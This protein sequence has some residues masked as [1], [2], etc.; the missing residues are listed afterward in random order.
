MTPL[1]ELLL[2]ACCI[3][4][5]GLFSGSE[6]AI[7]G[8][9]RLVL[10]A[11]A[12][13]GDSAAKRVLK[14]LERPTQLV[15]TCL[16]GTNV[17]TIAGATLVAHALGRFG[18]VPELL[19]VAVYTPLTI[20]FSEMVPKTI[21]Q[22]HAN[23][24]APLV[25]QPISALSVLLRPVLWAI[26]HATRIIMTVLGV[27]DAQVHAVRRED[28]QL[29]LDSATMTD[30]HD[31][32]KEMILRVFNFSETQVA[33]AMVP[34]I[35]V[36]GVPETATCGE[37]RSVMIDQGF[38]RLVIYRKRID[39]IVGMVMHSD[40]LFAPDDARPV[41]TVMHEIMFVPE[42]KRVDELFVD[43]RRKRQR[44]AVAVDEYGGAV[45]LISIEDILEEI[46]GDIEDEYDRA[47][48]LVRKM[49]ERQWI[50]SGRVE[51]EDLYE[52]T[53]FEMPEGDYETLAGFLLSQLGH[54][55]AAGERLAWGDFVLTVALA[56]ERA[57]LEV[58][59]QNTVP[60]T[61][62]ES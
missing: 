59:V 54:V 35:E 10:R 50:A 25:S 51:G 57:I 24:L 17:A 21:F 20:I 13:N 4:A 55:P 7:V 28:I 19:V 36:V 39:R 15:G 62:R 32:E 30:I 16:I 44:L 45:G 34:L 47:R 41:S 22:Q 33:D 18:D 40:L 8:S 1:G 6:I 46:V 23:T 27:K 58:D 29:L 56:N 60:R 31:D 38:S 49:G 42:T 37:A 9:D 43:L 53:G 11:R 52:T 2:I 26:E 12:E 48:P 5:Q 3:L 14:L 61:A